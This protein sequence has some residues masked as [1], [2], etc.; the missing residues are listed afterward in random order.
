M[1]S[2]LHKV[3]GPD[4]VRPQNLIGRTAVIIGG[5]LGIG[6]EVSRALV[7]AGC[8]VIMV[9]RS[10][11]QGDD[12]ISKLKQEYPSADV[13]WRKCDMG[14]LARVKYEFSELRNSLDRLDFLVLSAGLNANPFGLDADGIDRHFGVNYLG[15]YYATNQLWPLIRKTSN[16]P[17]VTAPR[18]VAIS[19]ELHRT[20]PSNIRFESLD[21]INN[22]QLGPTELYGRSKLALILFIRFGLVERVIKPCSDSIYAMSVHPGAVSKSSNV[23]C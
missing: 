16:M 17:G 11:D 12:A 2:V 15:Q 13:Q 18:V 6:Y 23:L 10:E 9:N 5:A 14:T 22:D 3:V 1:Q 21:E 7:L 19:S 20:A 8:K 4:E